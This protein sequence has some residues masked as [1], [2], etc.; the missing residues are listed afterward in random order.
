MFKLGTFVEIAA[1]QG[2]E[3]R[4]TGKLESTNIERTSD[5]GTGDSW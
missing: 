5:A 4:A 3:G 1:V 2:V